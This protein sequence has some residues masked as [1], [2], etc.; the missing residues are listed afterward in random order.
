M[1]I[2]S[3]SPTGRI[4][5]LLLFSFLASCRSPVEKAPAID[6]GFTSYITAFTSGQVGKQSAIRVRLA[7]ENPEG[8]GEGLFN[9]WA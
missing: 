8:F 7:E 5:I 1:K 6:P 4:V 2:Q 3:I 9:K